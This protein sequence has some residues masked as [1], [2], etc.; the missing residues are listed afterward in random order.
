MVTLRWGPLFRGMPS[1]G[2]LLVSPIRPE[3]P[4]SPYL[5]EYSRLKAGDQSP[6]PPKMEAATLEMYAFQ[7]KPSLSLFW[8]AKR[9]AFL[10]F[11]TWPGKKVLMDTNW[12]R[13]AGGRRT[14]SSDVLKLHLVRTWLRKWGTSYGDVKTSDEKFSQSGPDNVL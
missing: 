14:S 8:T 10:G 1:I 12:V 5:S 11:L 13:L 6:M 9:R 4:V 3:G 2:E 7:E